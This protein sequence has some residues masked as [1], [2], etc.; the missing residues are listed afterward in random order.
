MKFK[1]LSEGNL[2]FRNKQFEKALHFYRQARQM[3][4][5]LALMIDTNIKLASLRLDQ[6][7][8]QQ[9]EVKMHRI[10][11]IVSNSAK[12]NGLLNRKIVVYTAVSGGY[13]VLQDPKH[14]LPNCDYI[15]FS[16]RPLDCKVWQIRPFNYFESDIARISR[17][18]KLHPHIYFPNYKTSIW[19]DANISL[20][21]DPQPFID[22]LGDDGLMA[23]FP[24]PHR[25]CVYVE[26]NECIKRSKDNS[27]IIESQLSKYKT[28]EFPNDAGLWETGVLV[29]NHLDPKCKKLMA[30]WWKEI[31]LGS[32][33]DQISL[34]VA[35]HDCG[36][37][38]RNLAQKGTDL[39]F[40]S[41]LEFKKHSNLRQ[42]P[43]ATSVILQNLSLNTL[44]H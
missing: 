21:G 27:V 6:I 4:P 38:V 42:V 41:L 19:I 30:A 10:G 16:D 37:T 22:C 44:V 31:F 28:R 1:P 12:I 29:R 11:P 13:D 5:E 17:F 14:V 33:R 7:L 18:V 43:M 34:P 35:I 8:K 40:H 36:A 2:A 23:L 25:N 9:P 24:H 26:G 39:R 3:H 15:A 20:N 32:R